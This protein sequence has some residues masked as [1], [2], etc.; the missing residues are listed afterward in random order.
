MTHPILTTFFLLICGFATSTFAE[1][2][3]Q[4]LAEALAT[5]DLS[6]IRL[7]VDRVKAALGPRAGVPEVAD[8]Y[9]EVPR[10]ETPLTRKEIQDA[11]GVLLRQVERK[12]FW[13]I[14]ID[15]TQMQAPLRAPASILSASIALGRSQL[16]EEAIAQKQAQDTAEFLLW[17]Q[18]QAGADCFPFPAA[19]NTSQDRA[20]QVATQFLEKAK[21]K[22]RWEQTVRNGWIFADHGDGG[23]QF[24]NSECGVAMFEYY[25]WTKE[26]K[27]L[28][29]AKRA[30]SWALNQPL[31]VNW[32]YNAFSVELLAKAYAV[33]NEAKYLDAAVLKATHGVL[34]G[35]LTD[36]P[37][38]GRW[39]DP[40][41]AR[42]AYHYIILR[43]LARLWHALPESHP[44]R[45]A[46][47][48]SL[49]LGLQ[50]RNAEMV[51]KGIMTKDVS[52]ECLLLVQHLFAKDPEF[53]QKTQ[54]LEAF[55][56]LQHLVIQ[57]LRENKMAVGPKAWGDWLAHCYRFQTER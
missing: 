29:S 34:P 22:G 11:A 17:T 20:M 14:D 24:D 41:N 18:T 42:P 46:I 32:N 7:A 28:E 6:Q 48:Q 2:P 38:A 31:C 26:P 44:D 40:H 52:M 1:D 49:L 25:E 50:T 15:P 55:D 9:M 54:T 36:G 57:Q 30:A 53:L 35:Q 37:H 27:Y 45:Q 21:S 4:N 12:R 10:E 43:A 5:K 3:R 19:E 51:S 8:Q 33:T 39:L 13:N 47:Y 23:L 16:W 56:R